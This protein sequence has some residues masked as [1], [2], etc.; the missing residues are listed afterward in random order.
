M[1]TRLCEQVASDLKRKGYV[2]RTIGIKLRFD[3]FSTV[4]RDLTI[5][6]PIAEATSIRRAAGQC[7]QRVDLTRSIRLIGVRASTLERADAAHE[8]SPEQMDLDLG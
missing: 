6:A 3:D 7:L 8:K 2:G 5:P 1:L 4:T